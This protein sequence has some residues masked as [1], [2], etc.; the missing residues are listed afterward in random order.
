MTVNIPP[1]Q[2]LREEFAVCARRSPPGVAQEAFWFSATARPPDRILSCHAVEASL[3]TLMGAQ[4]TRHVVRT[5]PSPSMGSSAAEFAVV[6]GNGETSVSSVWGG[7]IHDR[8]HPKG[9]DCP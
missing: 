2:N 9:R 5:T 6:A 8:V 1:E 3:S 7:L 4:V